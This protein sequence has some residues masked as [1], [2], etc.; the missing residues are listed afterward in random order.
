MPAQGVTPL[1]T[2]HNC[3]TK[4]GIYRLY[5]GAARRY[6]DYAYIRFRAQF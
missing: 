4:A 1:P 3:R 5:A 6:V 2:K